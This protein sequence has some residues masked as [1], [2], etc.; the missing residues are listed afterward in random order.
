MQSKER[1]KKITITGSDGGSIIII[2]LRISIF[3]KN[4]KERR[5]KKR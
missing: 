1:P 3:I 4:R 5:F 2:L